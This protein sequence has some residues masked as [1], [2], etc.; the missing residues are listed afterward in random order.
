[1]FAAGDE[2]MRTQKGNNNPYNQD[3]ETSW[4]DWTM[5]EKNNG[6]FRFFQRMIAFRK[7]HPSLCRSRFWRDDVL[8][9]GSAAQ[10]DQSTESHVL[11][12]Y[13]RGKSQDDAD[14]YVMHQFRL[15]GNDVPLQKGDVDS[16]RR[17]I[18]TSLASPDDIVEPGSEA[19]IQSSEYVVKGRS[20]VVLMGKVS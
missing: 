3:N 18:D 12:F 19:G 15:P 5:L 10:V 14:L 8:W 16:W 20:I 7:A 17:V 9:F 4:I 13:L 1:M 2:F 6:M 11:A